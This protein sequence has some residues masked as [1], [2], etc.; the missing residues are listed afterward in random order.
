MKYDSDKKMIVGQWGPPMTVTQEPRF[1]ANPNG[2]DEDDGIIVMTVYNFK[3][4]VSSIVVID[5][6]TM[7]QLQEYPLPFKLSI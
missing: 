4:K 5:P 6:K 2:T 7:T 3:N 1:I